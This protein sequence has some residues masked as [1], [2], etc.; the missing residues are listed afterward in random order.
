MHL[1][2]TRRTHIKVELL[3]SNDVVIDNLHGIAIDGN[4][5]INADSLIRR[6]ANIKFI[7]YNNL[8]PSQENRLW[9][10]NRIRLWVGLEGYIEDISWF[11]LGIF[12]INSPSL[13]ISISEKTISIELLDKMSVL[14][15]TL[16]ENRVGF[17]GGTSISQAMQSVLSIK[18]GENRLLIDT[19]PYTIPSDLEF[20]ATDSV[21]DVI[22]SLQELYMNWECF[23]DTKGFFIFKEI[24][25]RLN[26]PIIW[27]FTNGTDFRIN[28]STNYDYKN[29]K[30]YVKVLGRT[31]DNGTTVSAVIQNDNPSSP[32]SIDKIG[33][34]ALVVDDDK[35]QTNEQC[36]QYANY[37]L[38][39]HGNFN[40]QVSISTVPIYKLGVNNL[41]NFNSPD[42]GLMGKYCISN[43][44][45][46]LRFDSNMSFTAYKIY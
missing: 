17:K 33:E 29:I 45:L 35:Y 43:I 46:P 11:D 18:G 10:N 24:P 41:V 4:V 31:L 27:D 26:D 32:F 25:N 9:I 19:H 14:E 16:L 6:T 39:K 37:L 2:R 23:Y 38:F 22:K 15:D 34:K 21:L 30:N 12:I 20:A 7:L 1:Q 8:L 13:N 42:D 44:S 28:S 36:Q 3:N 40:E 5:D